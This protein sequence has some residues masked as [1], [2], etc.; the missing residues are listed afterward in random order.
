MMP[1]SGFAFDGE[2]EEMEEIFADR[3][4]PLE[5][6]DILDGYVGGPLD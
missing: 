1:W 4:K 3:L 6:H 2:K 5:K